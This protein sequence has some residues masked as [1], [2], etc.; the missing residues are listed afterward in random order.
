MEG[1]CTYT[2]LKGDF[3]HAFRYDNIK[4]IALHLLGCSSF[5]IPQRFHQRGC[6]SGHCNF[7]GELDGTNRT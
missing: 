1:D 5:G 4:R 7:S 6:F 2:I 3:A